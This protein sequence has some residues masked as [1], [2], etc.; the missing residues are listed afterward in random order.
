MEKASHWI[1]VKRE[2]TSWSEWWLTKKRPHSW[3]GRETSHRWGGSVRHNSCREEE[4]EQR[5]ILS[6]RSPC[7]SPVHGAFNCVQRRKLFRS[8]ICTQ[9]WQEVSHNSL[10]TSYCRIPA[11]RTRIRVKWVRSSRGGSGGTDMFCEGWNGAVRDS[12]G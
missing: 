8:I 10:G 6:W 1:W 12:K 3:T 4:P 2:D 11:K 9:R 7:Q 5:R